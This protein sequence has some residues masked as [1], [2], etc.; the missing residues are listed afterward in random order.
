MSTS[1]EWTLIPD[2]A[3]DIEQVRTRCRRLVRR[4]A[5]LSA[6]V[7][8]LPVPGVDMVSDLGLLTVLVQEINQAFGLT[9]AQIERLQPKFKLL[10]YEAAAGMGG[11]LVG[12]LV[13]R[14]LLVQVLKRSGMKLLTKQA[15]R[16]VPLAGQ[17]VSAAIGFAVFRQIGYQHVEACAAVAGELLAAR[18]S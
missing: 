6:A 13:T 10:A 15:A 17:A 18:P 8:A 16:L 11:V 14:E 9:P 5:A 4:R 12:K 2:S 1:T 3:A 7:S